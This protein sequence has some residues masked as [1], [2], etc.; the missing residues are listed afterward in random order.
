V[1]QR[2]V[3]ALQAADDLAIGPLLA[4]TRSQNPLAML[5]AAHHHHHHHHHHD[6]HHHQAASAAAAFA[7]IATAGT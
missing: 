3:A 2:S 5:F 7:I 6:H 4:F 1:R